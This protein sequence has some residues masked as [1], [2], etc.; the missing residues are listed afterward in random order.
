M[1][2]H[3]SVILSTGGYLPLVPG[4]FVTSERKT[5]I[6]LQCYKTPSGQTPPG[7]PPGQTPPRADTT[8]G[9]HPLGRHPQP[10]SRHTPGRHPWPSACWDT[11]NK[12]A[13]HIRLECIPVPSDVSW[14]I[15]L[16]SF[17]LYTFRFRQSRTILF[18]L[19]AKFPQLHLSTDIISVSLSLQNKIFF[20]PKYSDET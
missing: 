13:V 12:R 10:P 20:K 16:I 15:K 8:L 9:R 5:T 7:R 4:V 19:P 14:Q 6:V 18:L 17:K 11:V 1:F 3:L 2:L